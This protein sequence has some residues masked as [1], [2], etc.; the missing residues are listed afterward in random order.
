MSCVIHTY[1]KLISHNLDMKSKDSKENESVSSQLLI[2][3]NMQPAGD[4]PLRYQGGG[5]G[6]GYNQ[7]I[8]YNKGL[9]HEL[10]ERR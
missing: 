5:E 6:K 2:I 3:Q 1:N 7:I 4:G 9:C 10:W 8:S